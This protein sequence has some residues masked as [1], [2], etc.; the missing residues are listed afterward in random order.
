MPWRMDDVPLLHGEGGTPFKRIGL[1]HAAIAPYGVFRAAMALISDLHSERREWRAGGKRVGDAALASNPKF[2]TS[3]SVENRAETDAKVAADF[4]RRCWNAIKLEAADIAFARVND[5]E[6]LSNMR[7][8]GGSLFARRVAGEMPAPALIRRTRT[9][10]ADPG[11]ATPMRYAGNLRT[12]V[13]RSLRVRL[14][15]RAVAEYCR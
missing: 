2:A 11:S 9:T 3:R 6:L 10:M 15:R 8:C 7:I 1:A 5:W 4:A 13:S 14:L 12:S